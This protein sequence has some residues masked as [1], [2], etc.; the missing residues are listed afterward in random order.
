MFVK[1]NSNRK[2]NHLPVFSLLMRLLNQKNTLS[3]TPFDH[4]ILH[5][6]SKLNSKISVG[7]YKKDHWCQLVFHRGAKLKLCSKNAEILYFGQN[8][9]RKGNISPSNFD[10]Q[11]PNILFTCLCVKVLRVVSFYSNVFVWR[12]KVQ[13]EYITS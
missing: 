9:K 11:L 4:P 13:G 6:G 2:K 3:K 10:G 1:E 8:P 5:K 7:K 12:S